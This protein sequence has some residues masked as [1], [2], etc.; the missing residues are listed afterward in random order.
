MASPAKSRAIG[1]RFESDLGHDLTLGLESYYRNWNVLGYMRMGATI[2]TNLTVPDVDTRA[3]GAFADYRHSFGENIK[4]SGGIRF[5]HASMRVTAPNA[6]TNLYDFYHDTRRTSSAD[7]YPSG[8]ARISFLLPRSTEWFLGVGS[9]ARIPDAEERYISRTSKTGP[10]VGNPLL[11][12]TRNTEFTVG[13]NV[14]R[15]ASYIKPVLF[16][17]LLNDYIVLNNQ[18]LL[19]VPSTSP[20]G[21]MAMPSATSRSYQNVDARIY[22]G[23]IGYALA[24]NNTISFSGGASYSRG[25]KEKKA[26]AGILTTNLAEMPPLRSWLA[27]RYVYKTTFAEVGGIAVNRQSSVDGDV[28]ETATPGY[29]TMNLKLGTHYKKINAM[30]AIDNLLNRFYYEHLSYYRDPF[31]SGVKVPEPGRSVFGQVS[32]TF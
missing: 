23:E 5:D 20:M 21:S 28:M 12:P 26:S 29:F 30:F 15:G 6:S 8:N 19:N 13:F 32:Y 18:P 24:V 27:M 16:Y 11:P 1:G 4:L 14:R 22:G 10:N 31:R 3:T 9:T 7:N 17:S 25:I 2:T